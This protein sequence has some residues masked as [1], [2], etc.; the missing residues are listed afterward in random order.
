M[1]PER[2][3]PGYGRVVERSTIWERLRRVDP[4]VWDSILAAAVLVVTVVTAVGSR[5]A[6]SGGPPELELWGYLLI[7]GG[8]VPLVVRRRWPIPVLV[9]VLAFSVVSSASAEG[10]DLVLAVAIAAY[11]AAAHLPRDPFARSVVPIATVG[12]I[13]CQLVGFRTGNWVEVAIAATFSA[14]LPMLVGRIGFNRRRR[15][16]LDR[17]RAAHDAVVEERARIAR[18]LHD[19]VAHAM[20]V[21]VVQAGAARTVLDDDPDA[22]RAAIGRIES[23]GRD[24]LAEMRRLIGVLK[25]DGTAEADRTPQP[26]LDQLDALLDTVRGAGVAVEVVTEGSRRPLAAGLDLIAYRVVQE[27][28]T[29]VIKHAGSANARVLFRW[30]D[31]T[32]DVEVADDGRGAIT[33]TGTGHGLLGMRERVAVY[34]GSLETRPRA[35]G[36]FVVHAR[37]PLD[38]GSLP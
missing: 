12:V 9:T 13:A 28:L 17:D 22:A 24:G 11:S 29:N 3:R 8:C 21:M 4:L 30:S 16:A 38:G 34:G 7:V 6:P 14:W 33:A 15:I 36:G 35:G 1:T 27:A 2:G 20:S 19:I 5:H 26:G 25:A 23:T 31:A 18:E 32:L 37:L 10:F